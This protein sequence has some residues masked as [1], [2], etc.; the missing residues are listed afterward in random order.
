M[1][2]VYLPAVSLSSAYGPDLMMMTVVVVGGGW[3]VRLKMAEAARWGD[4]AKVVGI[5][6]GLRLP[7]AY[8]YREAAPSLT[9]IASPRPVAGKENRR[10]PTDAAK[11]KHHVSPSIYL[12]VLKLKPKPQD[13]NLS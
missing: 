6:H 4:L 9:S 7:T 1:T 2:C 10:T 11:N 8:D 3:W 5:I 12:S 13:P